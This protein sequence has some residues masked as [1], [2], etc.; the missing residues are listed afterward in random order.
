MLAIFGM[1]MIV[2]P[3]QANRRDVLAQKTLEIPALQQ[4]L[5]REGGAGDGLQF[6][7]GDAVEAHG[8]KLGC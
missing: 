1:A 8:V 6:V 4:A 3:F 5:G 7:G 2:M